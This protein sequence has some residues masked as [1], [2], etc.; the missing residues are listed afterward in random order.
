MDRKYTVAE[1]DQMRSSIRW[2]YPCGVSYYPDQREREI[3]DRLRTYM[4]N[5]TEPEELVEMGR[6]AQEREQEIA[7]ARQAALMAESPSI[8][9][10]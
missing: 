2:S 8:E 4:L 9:R 10:R 3:E 5:G 6:R 1:I 7:L